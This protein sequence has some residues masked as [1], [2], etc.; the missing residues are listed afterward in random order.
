M[1]NGVVDSLPL[2]F[3]FILLFVVPSQGF[4]LGGSVLPPCPCYRSSGAPV[5][6]PLPPCPQSFTVDTVVF[7]LTTSLDKVTSYG[8][9]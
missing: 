5:R 3:V 9:L 1:E 8:A 4:R 6:Y 2:L 7:R